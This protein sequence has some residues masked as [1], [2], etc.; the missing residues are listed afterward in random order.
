MDPDNEDLDLN[1]E[2]I[3]APTEIEA[4]QDTLSIIEEAVAKQRDPDGAAERE[5]AKV[6]AAKPAA[7]TVEVAPKDGDQL[8]TP[9]PAKTAEVAPALDPAAADKPDL[10]RPPIGWSPAA[11]AKWATMDPD[12]K[13]AVAQRE[14]DVNKGLAKLGEYKGIDRFAEQAKSGG[15]TLESA[16]TA[17]TGMEALL[18]KDPIGGFKEL[19]KNLR[20]DP[21]GYV[22]AIARDLGIAPAPGQQQQPSPQDAALRSALTPLEQKLSLLEARDQERMAQSQA[23]ESDRINGQVQAFVADPK[24][25]YVGNVYPKMVEMIGLANLSKK[26]IDLKAIYDDACLLTPEVRDLLINERVMQGQSKGSATAAVA[27]KARAAA[28][29]T[30]GAP[31][32]GQQP[33]TSASRS[34]D[35]PQST[36]DIIQE[37]VDAQRNSAV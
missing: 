31:A 11:K 14:V 6:A 24:N 23:Q 4:P 8:K 10:S 7:K 28:R 37:A 22:L 13:A 1:N 9:T 32:P 33:R 20:V 35:Q 29:A 36:M 2:H 21:R 15:T 12:I 26:A 25:I 30:S 19:A 34:S 5:A 18:R 3:E 16:L 27:S 17:Y